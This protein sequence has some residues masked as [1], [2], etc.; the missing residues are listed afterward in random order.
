[1][2]TSRHG[3]T[4]QNTSVF[5]KAAIRTIIVLT[6]ARQRLLSGARCIRTHHHI[7]FLPKAPS[8]LEQSAVTYSAGFCS[9]RGVGSDSTARIAANGLRAVIHRLFAAVVGIC[10]HTYIHTNTFHRSVIRSRRHEYE[11]ITKKKGKERKERLY[12]L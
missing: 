10:L 9:T 5:I 3:V 8:R 4:S 7:S 2:F 6:R 11:I 1:M 12:S